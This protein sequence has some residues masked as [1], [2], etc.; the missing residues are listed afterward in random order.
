MPRVGGMPLSPELRLH[1]L[2]PKHPRVLMRSGTPG[3]CGFKG[4]RKPWGPSWP[5][6]IP[7][8]PFLPAFLC[9][10]CCSCM[11][12]FKHTLIRE[13]SPD[14]SPHPSPWKQLSSLQHA[15]AT[16]QALAAAL[17]PR[18]VL[19]MQLAL[20]KCILQSTRHVPGFCP[21]ISEAGRLEAPWGARL[22][23]G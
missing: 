19:G 14:P 5:S 3:P 13:D 11:S 10:V 15:G 6:F 4:S 2:C 23:L 1:Q 18:T 16:S 21:G 7:S 22:E 9:P 20:S 12:F 8:H 17:A